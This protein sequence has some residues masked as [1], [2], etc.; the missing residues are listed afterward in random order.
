M[1]DRTHTGWRCRTQRLIRT[2][3]GDLPRGSQGTIVYETENL[4]RQL[5]FVSWDTGISV[6]VFPDEIEWEARLDASVQ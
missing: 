4:G 3:K 6:P 2:V 5:I 1:I